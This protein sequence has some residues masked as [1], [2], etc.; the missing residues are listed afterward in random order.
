MY[1]VQTNNITDIHIG[2]KITIPIKYKRIYAMEKI[3]KIRMCLTVN[4][5]FFLPSH[6]QDTVKRI[7]V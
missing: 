3:L 6:T 1:P 5:N 2:K 4:K 7:K